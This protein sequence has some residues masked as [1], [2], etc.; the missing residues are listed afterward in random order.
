MD[1]ALLSQALHHATDPAQALAEAARVVRPGGKVLVLD[2]RAHDETWVRDKLG[3]RQ[4]GFSDD[5]TARR[6]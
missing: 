5:A 4:L 3:D 2:L 6:C 1:V